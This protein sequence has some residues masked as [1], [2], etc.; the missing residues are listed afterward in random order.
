ML[1]AGSVGLAVAYIA[2]PSPVVLQ[3]GV[4]T[5]VTASFTAVAGAAMSV[6]S[7][8]N[9]GGGGDVLTTPEVAGPRMVFRTAGPPA[10]AMLG[11]VPALVAARVTD[12]GE[13]LSVAISVSL[14]VL[15]LAAGVFAWVRFRSSIHQSMAE[16]MPQ[17]ES[18]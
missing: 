11:F 10:I 4:L 14:P 6:V 12:P 16:A 8:T 3:I 7:P 17:K 18:K 1:L 5:V 13:P 15:A 2:D 9:A